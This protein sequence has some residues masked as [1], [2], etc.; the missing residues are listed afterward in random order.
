MRAL[1]A[2]R[3]TVP[4]VCPVDG[5]T[6]NTPAQWDSHVID[7]HNVRP[8][9]LLGLTCPIDGETFSA[10]QVLGMHARREHD[11]THTPLLFQK[12]EELGDSLGIVAAIRARF[13]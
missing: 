1:V 11:C 12:A 5:E 4:R 8:A 9:E 2:A 13:A 10:P 6:S 7:T 3:N